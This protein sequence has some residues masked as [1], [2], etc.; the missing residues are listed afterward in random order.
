MDEQADLDRE[1]AL[2]EMFKKGLSDEIQPAVK[3]LSATLKLAE[4]TNDIE[5]KRHQLRRAADL[6]NKIRDDARALLRKTGKIPK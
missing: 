1:D 6:G 4:T 3:E 5:E 2:T